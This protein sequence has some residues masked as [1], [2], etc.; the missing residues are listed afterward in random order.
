MNRKVFVA[1][2]SGVIGQ[3]LVPL[4]VKA[5]YTVYGTTRRAERAAVLEGLGAEPVVV[6]VFDVER[7]ESELRRIAPAVVI[8]QLTDLPRDLDPSQMAQ[9]VVNNARIRSEGTRNLVQAALAAGSGRMIAQSVAWAFAP[10]TTPYRE[11]Q[12]L[13]LNA[14]GGRKTTVGGVAALEK[15]VLETPPLRGAV[16]RYGRLYGPRTGADAP[17]AGP[18]VY[19]DDAARAALLALETDATGLFNITNDNA[20]VSNEKA[21]RVLGWQP[22]ET[23]ALR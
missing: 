16:L 15:A 18:S 20:E 10:G 21:K 9:A 8:H 23:H 4:L 17:A 5:G 2:A 22:Q 19:V 11:E 14:E 3:A 12:P 6:D 1:G 7:L 13:D